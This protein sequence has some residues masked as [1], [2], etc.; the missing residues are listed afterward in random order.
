M[1]GTQ[2]GAELGRDY[3]AADITSGRGHAVGETHIDSD[4]KEYTFVKASSAIAQYDAVWI[5][6]THEAIPG[7][8]AAFQTSGRFAVAQVAITLDQYGW[9]QHRGNAI[10]SVLGS[11]AANAALYMSATA[12]HLDDA[13]LSV[14]VLGITLLSAEASSMA[15]CFMDNVVISPHALSVGS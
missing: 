1:T 13:T 3:T 15:A 11:C 10:L 7:T 12:G 9:V 14:N 2:I 8:A 5:K 6:S 4:G